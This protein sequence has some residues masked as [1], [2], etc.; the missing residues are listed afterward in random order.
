MRQTVPITH[1]GFRLRASLFLIAVG[2]VCSGGLSSVCFA[3]EASQVQMPATSEDSATEDSVTEDSGADETPPATAQI[4]FEEL[5]KDPEYRAELKLRTEAFETGR[6][7]LA[8]A[9]S[10]QH[11][12]LVRYRNEQATSKTDKQQ[13]YEARQQ[14]R[15]AMDE[16]YLL[17]MALGRIS[18]SADAG[19]YLVTM[20]KHRAEHG[21]YNYETAEGAA[22]MI[23]GGA[24]FLYLFH[25][26]ARSAV[27]SGQF[28]VARRLYEAMSEDDLEEIDRR[29]MYGF[30]QL[31]EN[32]L[33][34]Q[35]ILKQEAE[36]EELPRV[37]LST[38]E[39]DIVLELFLNQAPSATANFINLVEEGFYDGLDFH[40][41]IDDLLALTGDP[42]GLGDGHSGNFLVDEHHRPDARHGFRGS[43]VMAKIPKGKES[44]DFVPNS[45]SSQFAILMV[46][47]VGIEKEQTVFGR[48]VEGMNNIGSLRRVDPSKEKKK[49][50]VMLPSDHIIEATVIRR[51]KELPEPVYVD[52]KKQV[53]ELIERQRSKLDPADQ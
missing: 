41:V 10:D 11:S 45:A 40:Q 23:D 21:I 51:P 30:E 48:V 17:A 29:F 32:F 52:L 26:A 19:Q 7:K 3:Q 39:G 24:N 53:Q 6:N 35:E 13:Y 50:E 38:S 42:S 5:K 16:L 34:E 20:I 43:L 36:A 33:E 28:D 27:V 25:A 37:K 9:I 22:R 1:N 15:D 31:K 14:V 4:S 46:P 44:K 49:G 18:P 12:C 8:D 2:L 47:I